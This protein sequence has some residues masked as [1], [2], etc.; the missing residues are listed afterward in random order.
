M[1]V[2]SEV[3]VVQG[4]ISIVLQAEGLVA[5][6]VTVRCHAFIISKDRA[7]EGEIHLSSPFHS[8]TLL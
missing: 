5:H 4:F 7:E 6:G 8:N 3:R 2:K 1:L